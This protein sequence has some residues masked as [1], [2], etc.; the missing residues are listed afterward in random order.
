MFSPKISINNGSKSLRNTPPNQ[1]EK[2][3]KTT[4]FS[5]IILDTIWTLDLY[6][7]QKS[8]KCPGEIPLQ[9]LNP[10]SPWPSETWF[11]TSRSMPTTST[12]QLVIS[13]YGSGCAIL[14]VSHFHVQWWPETCSDRALLS[15]IGED[16]SDGFS[17]CKVHV[18]APTA[19]SKTQQTPCQGDNVKGV[20]IQGATHVQWWPG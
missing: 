14:D 2:P 11:E 18:V 10:L 17:S 9:G 7:H 5:S 13:S 15:R 3:Y 1:L 16:P 12:L 20:K 19:F 4:F 6:F 8:Q